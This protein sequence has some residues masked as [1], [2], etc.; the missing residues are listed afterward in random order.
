MKTCPV[1]QAEHERR[2]I[3]CSRKCCRRVSNAKARGTEVR[4]PVSTFEC[5][6]CTRVCTPG[7]DVSANA[8]RFC[9]RTCKRA[10]HMYRQ[11]R[12]LQRWL[13]A[14]SR[15]ERAARGRD[16]CGRSFA[17]GRCRHCDQPFVDTHPEA[18]YCSESC[19]QGHK[20][21]VRL[22]AIAATGEH[23]HF[24]EVGELAGWTCGICGTPVDREL[25]V[26]HR[27]APTVDHI[28]PLS[29]GGEHVADNVQLAH[30]TCNSSKRDLVAA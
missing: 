14:R 3:Y 29:R 8:S 30:L 1:C 20:R 15:L 23:L 17:A 27:L 9:D 4:A 18:R 10:W 11:P 21:A 13:D 6:W 22:A 28:I 19:Q 12:R 26:P 16:A 25:A 2:G 24:T 7:V 5:A